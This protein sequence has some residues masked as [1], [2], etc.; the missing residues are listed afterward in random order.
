MFLSRDSLAD[1]GAIGESFP[2]GRAPES[3]G[4]VAGVR[5]SNPDTAVDEPCIS[6]RDHKGKLAECGC[7]MRETTPE[8]PELP[9]DATEENREFLEKFLIDYY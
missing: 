8:P 5:A 7:P 4:A 2:M 1:L 9:V 3:Y 6:P